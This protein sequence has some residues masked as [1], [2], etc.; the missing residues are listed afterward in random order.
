[1]TGGFAFIAY[2]ENYGDTGITTFIINQSG[3]VYEKDLGKST[4]ENA[5]AATEFN[6]DKTW[7]QVPE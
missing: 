5:G 2:P 4:A 7:T 1:M 3:V 6:P